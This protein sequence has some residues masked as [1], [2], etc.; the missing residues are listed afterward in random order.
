M[1]FIS[2]PLML[3]SISRFHPGYHIEFNC[4]V[5]LVFSCLWQ[6]VRWSFFLF[7]TVLRSTVLWNVSCFVEWP[8]FGSVCC[9]SYIY[10][11]VMGFG[12]GDHRGKVPFLSHH[13]RCLQL[14][15]LYFSLRM[16]RWGEQEVEFKSLSFAVVKL[17][18][19]I[20]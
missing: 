2:F 6:S 8:Q 3:F 5:F 13:M 16:E 10:S 15:F 12:E 4:H 7:L 19:K 17:V 14:Y 20:S 11:R 1:G 18:V 9:F